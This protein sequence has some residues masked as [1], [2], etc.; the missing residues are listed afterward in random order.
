M[1]RGRGEVLLFEKLWR[2]RRRGVGGLNA[3]AV[4][5]RNGRTPGAQGATLPTEGG[6]ALGV[7]GRTPT[8][9]EAGV[10]MDERTLALRARWAAASGVNGWTPA[11]GMNWW[12]R[13]RV[14]AAGVFGQTG[15]RRRR[16]DA[17]AGARGKCA[18]AGVRGYMDASVGGKWVGAGAG[19]GWGTGAR[20]RFVEAK[21]G[22]A[23]GC[24]QFP[25]H[26]IS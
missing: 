13:R 19:G 16:R 11:F 9:G 10:W 18:D 15:G 17:G 26:P 12:K 2:S 21:T 24:A 25:G 6:S 22:V 7:T 23:K 20:A 1:E 4:P 8:M 3:G 14:V 5:G